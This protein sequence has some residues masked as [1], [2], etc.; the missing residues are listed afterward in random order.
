MTDTLQKIPKNWT[1]EPISKLVKINPK[2]GIP[3]LKKD[4][5]IEFIPMESVGEDAQIHLILFRPLLD[6]RKGYTAFKNN[7]VLFAKIT[8][9]MENGK[10]ALIK[11][12]KHDIGFGSTE[13]HVLRPIEEQDAEF[14]F[15][16]TR[17]KSFRN[18]AIKFFSGSAGQQRVSKDFFLNYNILIPTFTERNTIATIL[19]TIDDAIDHTDRLIQKYQRIKQG[20][21]QDLF[22]YGIDEQ[23]NLRSEKTNRFKDSPLGRI[24]EE[25][26]VR[27][28]G[29]ITNYIGSGITPTGGQEVYLS[30]GIRF[31]RSQNVMFG[32]ISIQDI[33]HIDQ[34]THKKMMRSEIFVND[35]LLNITG[36]SIGRCCI[37][38]ENFGPANVNQHVCA[39]RLKNNDPLLSKFICH[40]LSSYQGQN[41]IENLNAGSNRQGL[42]YQQIKAIKTIFP[43]FDEQSRIA[44]IINQSD[45]AIEKEEAHKQKL[46]AIKIGLMNDLLSGKVR[47]NHRILVEAQYEKN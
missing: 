29:D 39:I 21:M 41:Q 2:T 38:P 37:V 32:G 19:S 13:F 43:K 36:A 23:G 22:R 17:I 25:W 20:L 26:E 31:V 6:I 27:E 46:V 10:G 24:P 8:P 28:I 3:T 5:L 34:K 47:V 4:T 44:A 15:Q 18:E 42:N 11:G 30:E 16:L 12:L 14:I 1:C 35:V 7:D 33:A 40:F 45:E 9:C